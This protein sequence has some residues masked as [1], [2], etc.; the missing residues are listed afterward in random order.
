MVRPVVFLLLPLCA[1][2]CVADDPELIPEGEHYQYAVGEIMTPADNT[3]AR[4]YAFDLDGD[5]TPDNQLGMI[6]GFLETQGFGVADTVDESLL[7]GNAI[8]LV[9]LQTTGFDH[10]HA[11][12]LQ[13]NLGAHPVPAA[14]TD[15]ADLMTCGQHL[16]TRAHYD[17]VPET[18][19]DLGV[20]SFTNGQLIAPIDT[21]PISIGIDAA[22]P[23]R[24]DLHGAK[25]RV[26][27]ASPTGAT[28]VITGAI[29]DTDVTNVV[30]PEVTRNLARIVHDGGCVVQVSPVGC[31]CP[32]GSR[33][34]LIEGVFDVDHDCA[35]EPVEVSKN[36]LVVSLF[37]PDVAIEGHKMLSFG[38]GAKLVPA[39]Y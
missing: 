13:A 29:L 22:A 27:D 1:A 7:R 10:A 21:L 39:A 8:M 2:A 3:E 4:A 31:N 18:A 34:A 38:I 20:G 32:H 16:M 11:A 23:L 28:L 30:V 26:T 25:L 14:C 17:V 33:A 5:D 24:V 35:I 12:G 19:S 6:F 9:D 15:P 37:T 36:S